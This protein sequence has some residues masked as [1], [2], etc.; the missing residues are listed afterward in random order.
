MRRK[1]KT[2]ALSPFAL[3]LLSGTI[4]AGVPAVAAAQD[5]PAPATTPA[6]V[7]T[8]TPAP[9]VPQDNLIRSIAV[10]GAQRLEAQTI[11]SY[12]ALRPGQ[13]YTAAAADQALKDL[14]A[15]ELFVDTPITFNPATGEVLI[16][17]V[18]NPV[19]NRVV[20]EGNKRLKDDKIEPEIKLKPRQIFTRSK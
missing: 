15:T 13:A 11:L 8:P 17:V 9:A 16:T 14:A 4:L 20:L 6:P 10:A 7:A 3:A 1:A 19:I 12:I 5:T 2:I 18:E